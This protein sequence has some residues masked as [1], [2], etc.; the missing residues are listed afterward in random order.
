[1]AREVAISTAIRE[2]AERDPDC[3]AL[4]CEGTTLTRGDLERRTNRLA[5]DYE[6]RGVTKDSLVTI[7]LPNGTE[8]FETSI[9]VWKLGATPQPVSARLPESELEAIVELA[10]PPLVVGGP[11]VAGRPQLPPGHEPDPSISDE[12][13]DERIA[14]SWKAPTSG[15]STGRPK[16]I[17]ATTPGVARLGDEGGLFQ[18]PSDGVVLIPGALYHNAPFLMASTALFR[19]NHTIVMKRFDPALTLELIERHRAEWMW[20][21]PTMMS[22]IMG[23]EEGE[24]LSHDVSSLKTVWHGAAPCPPWVKE[25]WLEWLGPEKVWELYAGTEA[26]GGSAIRGD[27]WLEHR[28]SVGKPWGGP[29]RFK[30]VDPDGKELPVGEVGELYMLVPN[31]AT[32]KYLGAETK[33]LDGWESIGDMGWMDGDGYLYLADRRTDLIISGGANIYPAEVE[34]A[35]DEHPKVESCA[36]IGLPDDDLGQ[37][38]HA[39]VQ[40]R[41]EV[42]DDELLSFLSERLVRYKIP[43]S[44]ERTD[45]PLRDD[46]G[47]VR[48]SQLRDERVGS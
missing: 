47:K 40:P 42:G 8:F 34:A 23:L 27:E 29:E 6:S 24:R 7:A 48:R 9:A 26:Q 44:I 2:A 11:P 1:M 43:R 19:G 45:E 3:P 14:S 30:V 37:A 4:S 22:R 41:G 38:V 16:I 20:V 35:L 39:I 33:S 46:A 31:R 21:V 17:L 15:G 25:A 36:V 13:L 12:P 28:G 32:Y 18:F 10:D 5:R